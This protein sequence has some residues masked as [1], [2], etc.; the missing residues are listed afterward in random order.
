MTT[1]LPPL[2]YFKHERQAKETFGDFCQRKGAADLAAWAEQYVA[3]ST[4]GNGTTH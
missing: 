1:V 2:A 4:N 3:A